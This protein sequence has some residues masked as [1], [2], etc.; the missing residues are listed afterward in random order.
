[1]K[2]VSKMSFLILLFACAAHGAFAQLYQWSYITPEEAIEQIRQF[3]S[4]PELEVTVIS[5]PGSTNPEDAWDGLYKYELATPDH[6]YTLSDG[7]INRS[8]RMFWGGGWENF[9]GEESDPHVLA[10]MMLPQSEMDGIALGFMNTHFPEPSVLSIPPKTTLRISSYDF[11]REC[12]FSFP[13]NLPNDATGPSRCFVGVDTVLGKVTWYQSSHFP[14]LID[15]QPALT[16]EQAAAA[17]V[18]TMNMTD[19]ILL[20]VEGLYLIPPDPWGLQRLIYGLIIRAVP[21]Y[22]RTDWL[23]Y[24]IFPT[25]M[26]PE[27]MPDPEDM[28]GDEQECTFRILTDAHDG[29]V[30]H[31]DV[32]TG[33]HESDGKSVKAVRHAH[34]PY[35]S[36]K[37]DDLPL[38]LTS[39]PILIGEHAFIGARY[40]CHGD[41]KAS[42][43]RLDRSSFLLRRKGKEY[44]FRLNSLEYTSN[45]KSKKLPVSGQIVNGRLFLPIEAIEEVF[46]WKVEYDGEGM[47]I[48]LNSQHR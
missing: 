37:L 6:K 39:P 25:G 22:D 46:Q 9:Y 14:I 11:S 34:Y 4:D 21:P 32:L 48:E 8:H 30:M 40:L 44:T 45:G 36:M 38:Q 3:E 29:S 17:A 47:T 2:V 43:T 41:P 23:N 28:I 42:L 26:K 27:H 13:Q 18:T 35:L 33:L 16:A 10:R 31:W 24:W 15:T 20:E 1:M 5:G 19:A 12:M 7:R